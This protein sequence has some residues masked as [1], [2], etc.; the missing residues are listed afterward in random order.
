MKK[1]PTSEALDIDKCLNAGSDHDQEQNLKVLIEVIKSGAFPDEKAALKMFV[2]TRLALFQVAENPAQV[3]PVFE[4]HTI[5]MTD[6]QKL[7]L[8]QK[9]NEYYLNTVFGD[10]AEEGITLTSITRPLRA[11]I[12]RLERTMRP[13]VADIRAILK[14]AFKNEIERLPGTLAALEDKDRLN[15]LCKLMPFVLPKITSIAATKDEP[16]HETFR[17]W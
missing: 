8:A 1:K 5:G 16:G 13:Q 17:F 15:F 10:E 7:F 6:E 2:E 9:L 11:Y 14:E 3:V 4:Q 12:D